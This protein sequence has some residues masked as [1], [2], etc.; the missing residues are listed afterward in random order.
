MQSIGVTFVAI[1]FLLVLLK[2]SSR[3]ELGWLHKILS[4]LLGIAAG[5]LIFAATTDLIYHTSFHY[6]LTYT[7]TILAGVT[8]VSTEVSLFKML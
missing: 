7:G 5:I 6:V 8:V 4:I 3:V 2:L 1:S